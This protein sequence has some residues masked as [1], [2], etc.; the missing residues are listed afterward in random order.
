MKM[1]LKRLIS[2]VLSVGVLASAVQ[3]NVFAATT[4]ST[5][6]L[7]SCEYYTSQLPVT[8]AGTDDANTKVLT[9]ADGQLECHSGKVTVD[10]TFTTDSVA[11]KGT[12][13]ALQ[14]DKDGAGS[15]GDSVRLALRITDGN[16]TVRSEDQPVITTIRV[17]D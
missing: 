6:A 12:L 8:V 7:G 15:L 10:L 5:H 11:G 16:G 14:T 17:I 1:G 3:T 9:G 13:F 2:A 4:Q